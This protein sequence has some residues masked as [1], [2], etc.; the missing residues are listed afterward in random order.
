MGNE[1]FEGYA[2][3]IRYVLEVVRGYLADHVDGDDLVIIT[4]DHQPKFP[5]SSK[6]ATFSVPVHV[7]SRNA[8]AVAAFE[9]FGYEPGLVPSQQPP[10]P[11]MEDFFDQLA[12]VVRGER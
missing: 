9:R 1:Y 8:E 10:H 5:V 4:G 7:L 12:S 11:P 2:H 3:S 6:D